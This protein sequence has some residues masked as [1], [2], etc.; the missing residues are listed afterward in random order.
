[1]SRCI[2]THA[3]TPADTF[4]KYRRGASNLHKID[5]FPAHRCMVQTKIIILQDKFNR[6]LEY[7][8][9]KADAQVKILGY[10]RRVFSTT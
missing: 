9:S 3:C 8:Y 1:M 6:I 4:S 10:A 7:N 5:Q 2:L